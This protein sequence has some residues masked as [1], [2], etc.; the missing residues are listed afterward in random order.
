M[1]PTRFA[2]IG[3][4]AILNTYVCAYELARQGV[5]VSFLMRTVHNNEWYVS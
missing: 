5:R 1:D 4:S 2:R 3:T